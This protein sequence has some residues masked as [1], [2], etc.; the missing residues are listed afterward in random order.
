M[1]VRTDGATYARSA[2]AGSTTFAGAVHPG[3]ALSARTGLLSGTAHARASHSRSATSAGPAR[4]AHTRTAFAAAHAS[5]AHRHFLLGAR[6]AVCGHVVTL[7]YALHFGKRTLDAREA[8]LDRRLA[9]GSPRPA[10]TFRATLTAAL[11]A[12]VTTTVSAIVAAPFAAAIRPPIGTRQRTGG[13]TT[14]TILALKHRRRA[15]ALFTVVRSRVCAAHD[16]CPRK[17]QRREC[18]G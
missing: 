15:A 12:P 8:L 1:S 14:G 5:H 11:T 18:G 9:A 4:T 2:H 6:L 7:H 13:P 16:E 3:A 17:E 10:G